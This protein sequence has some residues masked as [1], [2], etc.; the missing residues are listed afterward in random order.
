MGGRLTLA[1]LLLALA[2]GGIWLFR[3]PATADAALPRDAAAIERGRYLVHAGGCIPCHAGADGSAGL[4][5]GRP[6][7][8]PF[9]TFRAPNITPDP[10][11]GIAGW[12]GREFVL[13]LRH[14]RRPEGGFYFPAFPYRAYAGLTT[15]D[16]LD[17]GA[18]LL[19]QP[20]V[21]NAV[22]GHVLPPWLS[23]WLMAGWN[24]L[25]DRLQATPPP[26]TD[27]VRAR[28]AYLVRHLGHCGECHTPRNALGIPRADSELAGT[29]LGEQKIEAIDA[30]ALAGWSHEEIETLLR[31]GMKPDI[32]FVGGTMA[33]V[34]EHNTSQLTAADRAAMA[35]FLGQAR[36]ERR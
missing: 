11:T 1:V 35:R 36:T 25:A 18:W 12:G 6:I 9:G 3:L 20:P 4:S 16:I 29:M 32:D 21:R 22:P 15:A 8:S 26:E 13:A 24:R 28:G 19:A 33:E 30:A 10:E 31:L 17:I 34:I 7:E 27:P 5:G 2:G 14:G 23:P